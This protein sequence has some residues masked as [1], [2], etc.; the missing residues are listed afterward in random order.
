MKKKRAEWE[1]EGKCI[2]CGKM[3]QEEGFKTCKTC[4]SN[5]AAYKKMVRK[6]VKLKV[7]MEVD[8]PGKKYVL[9]MIQDRKV[10]TKQISEA[11]GVAQ[12]TVELWLQD[13]DQEP[14]SE[15]KDKIN[16]YF[17]KKLF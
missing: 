9:Q 14:N 16:K 5:L 13:N 15:N 4:R 17:K 8:H 6:G 12:R 1:K 7:N 3:L 2:R 10:T 11:L